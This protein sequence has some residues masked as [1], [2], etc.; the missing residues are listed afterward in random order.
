GLRARLE[1][2]LAAEAVYDGAPVA[3]VLDALSVARDLGDPHVLVEALSLTHHALLSPEHLDL[4]LPLADEL[5]DVASTIGDG[6]RVLFGLMW[7]AVDLYL[8]GDVRA[9][10]VLSE[11]RHRADAV[12]CRSISYIVAAIDVMRLIRSGALAE[13]ETAAG[14]CLQLGLEVGDADAEGYFAAHLLTIRWLQDRDGELLAAVREVADSPSLVAPEFSFRAT[15]ATMMARAGLRDDAAAALRALAVDGLDALPRSSTWLVG[16]ASIGEAARVLGDA[17]VASQVYALL[18]PFSSRPVMP[19][20]A[21]SCFGSVEWP[22]GLAASTVGDTGRAVEHLQRAVEANRL[23]GNR[24]LTLVVQADLAETRASRGEPG[25]RAT[26]RDELRCAAEEA[27][28]LGMTA[29]ASTWN[30]RATALDDVGDDQASGVLRRDG[31][32]WVVAAGEREVVA[33]DLVGFAYL[34]TLLAHP[35]EE[36]PAIELCGGAAVDD[37]GHSMIDREAL[38]SYRDRVREIDVALVAAEEDSDLGRVDQLRDEREALRS[39]LSSVLA[40]NGRPRRFVDST[41]R[42]RTAVRKAIA[43]AIDTIDASDDDLGAELRQTISTGRSCVYV[44]DPRRPRR[45]SVLTGR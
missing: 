22:L 23:L 5:I 30:E 29:K 19:S 45:W 36:I 2:R 3:P 20:L 4:R 40:V 32:R 31:K 27:I 24:P 35:G 43:R 9:E 15:A 17:D 26:A 7:K 28:A 6:V 13:A 11:L 41:E 42:A 39:E 8:L 16:I 37:T 21:V 18:L 44:P 12:G 33:P 14:V 34:G 25:D 38:D 1:V 10:R